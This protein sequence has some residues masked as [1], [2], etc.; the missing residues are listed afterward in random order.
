MALTLMGYD[1][2]DDDALYVYAF[3]MNGT[4][5]LRTAPAGN[6]SFPQLIVKARC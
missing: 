5:A 1:D 6:S 3:R 4:R 2:D